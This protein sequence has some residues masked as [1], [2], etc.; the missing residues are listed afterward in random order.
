MCESHRA[1]ELASPVLVADSTSAPVDS[2]ADRPLPVFEDVAMP[3][4]PFD[5]A[6]IA[7]LH[8]ELEQVRSAV[9]PFDVDTDI[10]WLSTRTAECAAVETQLAEWEQLVTLLPGLDLLAADAEQATRAYDAVYAVLSPYFERFGSDVAAVRSALSQRG[11]WQAEADRH[12]AE[13]A[14]IVAEAGCQSLD[15]LAHA[16]G[17]AEGLVATMRS[18]SQPLLDRAPELWQAAESPPGFA[19]QRIAEIEQLLAAAQQQR[20]AA[21]AQ[22]SAGRDELVRLQADPAAAGDPITQELEAL[23]AEQAQLEQQRD[24]IAGEFQG[25]HQRLIEFQ[26]AERTGLEL[27]ITE[28]FREF[29]LTSDRRVEVDEQF[30]IHLVNDS[31]IR[32]EPDQLSH[33]ARD[34]LYLA[35]YFAT[36]SEF[37][38]PFVLDDPFVNCDTERLAAIRRLWD[39]LAADRQLILLSHDVQFAT[40]GTPLELREVA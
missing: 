15:D 12:A 20:E 3:V 38:L 34:Q 28:M 2:A 36:A 8:G 11:E 24:R 39:R 37:D 23:R 19:A 29:S 33:G 25:S 26:R 32:Y 30:R 21:A 17:R 18:E 6:V 5:I 9:A 27:R 14:H 16:A 31:G 4:A 40:W 1:A 35:V 7:A 13:M 10:D 22:Q